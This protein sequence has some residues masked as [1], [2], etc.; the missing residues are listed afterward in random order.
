MSNIEIITK[1]KNYFSKRNFSS[2]SEYQKCLKIFSTNF[3][4]EISLKTNSPIFLDTNVLLRY[5][6]ISFTA[7]EKLFQFVKENQKRIV[8]SKQVQ[9]EFIRNREDVIQRFFEQVTTKIPKD[10]N[11]DIVNKM[12]SFL[13]YHKIVLKDYPFVEDGIVHYQQKLEE[14]LKKLNENVELKQKELVNLF[15]KDKFLDLLNS[16]TVYEGLSD[17]ETILVKKNFDIMSSSIS[18]ENL[19]SLMNKPQ[20]VFPGIGDIK[21][22]PDDP[23]GDFIIFHEMMKYIIECKVNLIFLTFDN[24][25]GDWMTKNRSPH[26]HYT[27]NMYANTGKMIY[28]VDAERTLGDLLNISIE[29]LVKSDYSQEN[30]TLITITTLNDFCDTFPMFDRLKDFRFTPRSVRELKLNGYLYI[31]DLE[32]DMVR[33]ATACYEYSK[34]RHISFSRLGAMRTCLKI[35]K[36]SYLQID[37]DGTERQLSKSDLARYHAFRNLIS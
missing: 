35:L 21:G 33:T 13:D 1:E 19:D 23:Y 6:S 27:L 28:I 4:R 7:R 14:I 12:K 20:A 31:E 22:K 15:M 36:D 17:E 9:Y 24:S 3:E 25:K 11:T 37:L 16:C 29:S 30:L 5:Y 34:K 8:I 10:F 18:N 2:I 26:L 32:K